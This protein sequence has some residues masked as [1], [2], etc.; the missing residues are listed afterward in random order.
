MQLDP[1]NSSRSY[2]VRCRRVE[3]VDLDAQVVGEEV[4]RVGVVGEDAADLGG[5]DHDDVGPLVVEERVDDAAIAQVE[6]G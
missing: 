2:A 1:R 5:G 4:G 3:H 6:L